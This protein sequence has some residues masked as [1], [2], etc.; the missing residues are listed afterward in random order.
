M[1]KVRSYGALM[2]AL[3]TIA[4][5]ETAEAAECK[6]IPTPAPK[7]HVASRPAP[8]AEQRKYDDSASYAQSGYDYRSS[9]RVTESFVRH[10][11]APAPLVMPTVPPPMVARHDDGFRVAPA[12]ARIRFYRDEKVI[13]VP[14]AAYPPPAYYPVPQPYYPPPQQQS[15]YQGGQ[16]YGQ[17]AYGELMDGDYDQDSFSGGVGYGA[18]ADAGGG[19]GGMTAYLYNG[20]GGSDAPPNGGGT[21]LPS[22][23]GP[24]Y[25][26]AWQ[27]NGVPTRGGLALPSKSK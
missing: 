27:G 2:G 26:N 18:G 20:Q 21:N 12:D 24:G 4:G 3:L 25:L 7:H 8:R 14:T 16:G 6:C 9:S 1:V 19:G 11:A 10:A 13:Y 23:Y 5:A 22:S 15:Y 17:A